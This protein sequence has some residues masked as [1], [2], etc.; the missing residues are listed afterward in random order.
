MTENGP[1]SDYTGKAISGWCCL[2]CG[3]WVSESTHTCAKQ[4]Q[5]N[6]ILERILL[7][8]QQIKRDLQQIRQHV[9]PLR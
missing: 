5:P 2:N 1:A 9:V 7:E 8:L 4:P 6:D 3:A